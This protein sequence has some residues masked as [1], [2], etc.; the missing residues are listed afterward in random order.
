MTNEQTKILVRALLIS[1]AIFG[2]VVYVIILLSED[3]TSDFESNRATQ[4]QIINFNPELDQEIELVGNSFGNLG[5]ILAST[6]RIEENFSASFF[7]L[8]EDS[9]PILGV[10]LY[11]VD[12]LDSFYSWFESFNLTEGED[13][14]LEIYDRSRPLHN[15]YPPGYARP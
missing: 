1:M 14:I 8:E 15:D 6:P 12:G 2:V 4:E 7:P 13:V 10:T 3:N 11:T 5:L 9:T